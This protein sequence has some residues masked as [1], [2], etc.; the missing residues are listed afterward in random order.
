MLLRTVGLYLGATA[1]RVSH[2]ILR[3][4]PNRRPLPSWT[5]RLILSV[6]RKGDYPTTPLLCA[7]DDGAVRKAF[8]RFATP[9]AR[10]PGTEVVE[11]LCVESWLGYDCF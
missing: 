5:K 11:R 1:I 8:A 4:R 9:E 2:F 6:F 3:R 10:A 7:A